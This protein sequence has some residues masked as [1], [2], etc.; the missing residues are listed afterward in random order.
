ML[1]TNTVPPTKKVDITPILVSTEPALATATLSPGQPASTLSCIPNT[2]PKIGKVLDVVDG[3]TITVLL[4]GLVVKVKY[5]GIDAPESVTRLEYLGKEAR[6]RNQELVF[7]RD[8]LLYKDISDRDRFDHLLRYVLVEDR[9]VNLELVSLGYANA[10]DEAPNSACDLQFT[11]AASGARDRSLGIW[12]PHTPLPEQSLAAEG[13]IIFSVNKEAEFVDIQNT[14]DTAFDLSG[15][16]LV[17]EA[18]KQECKLSGI[19]QPSEI[20]RIFSGSKQPG[21][22]CGFDQPIWDASQTDSVVLYSPDGRETDR[23]P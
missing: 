13:L 18:G 15:W 7:G 17:S 9:F 23:Y 2:T 11:Q 10:L 12:A 16:Q 14:T 8:V 19:I 20:L 4:D 5:I 3:D 6:A 21:F 22:S 1:P